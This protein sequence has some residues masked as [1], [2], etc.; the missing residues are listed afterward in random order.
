MGLRLEDLNL[1]ECFYEL[2]I[3]LFVLSGIGN[4]NV[5]Y[6][7]VFKEID[8]VEMILEMCICCVLENFEVMC[9]FGGMFF[10]NFNG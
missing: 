2:W 3:E 6:S 9:D 10:C 8:Y 1:S 5:K 7:D 4:E